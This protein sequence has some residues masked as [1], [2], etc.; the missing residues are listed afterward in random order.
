[1]GLGVPELRN[2]K[3]A[4]RGQ[5]LVENLPEIFG[6]CHL[7]YDI[8]ELGE[9]LILEMEME[10]VFSEV[11][12]HGKLNA[13]LA[14]AS[15]N[16]IQQQMTLSQ[17]K[18]KWVTCFS[19]KYGTVDLC[20]Y[21]DTEESISFDILVDFNPDG[22]STLKRGSQFV[23]DTLLNL[24]ESKTLSDV[25]FKCQGK[26]FTAHTNILASSS[27][28][29]AAMFL[30]D[31]KEK[32]DRI[33]EIT[34]FDSRVIENLLRYLYTGE[35]FGENNRPIEHVENLFAAADKYD[36][37]SL[38]EECEFHLSKNLT[39][40]NITRYLVLAHRHNSPKL[41]ELTLDFI[42]ENAAQTVCSRKKTDWMEI[43]KG[44]PELAFQVMERL[45]GN[46]ERR[47]DKPNL[48]GK[49]RTRQSMEN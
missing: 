34:D 5:V 45:A 37:E 17:S 47:T 2:G 12:T 32:K 4:N 44:D 1:L 19:V 31:F 3:I 35:V 20:G 42:A 21:D 38:K 49:K 25:T 48:V 16:G 18:T 7:N 24:W 39:V 41:H 36:I 33:V 11:I 26:N 13:V 43:M 29:L 40:Y 46:K 10:P 14:L 30:N 15:H 9:K 28:V 6:S 23:R 22:A 27:P 8:D